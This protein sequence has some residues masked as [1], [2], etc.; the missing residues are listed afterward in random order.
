MMV[1]RTGRSAAGSFW[2]APLL[3]HHAELD[4]RVNAGWPSF[5]AALDAAAK[6]FTE[7]TYANANH[8]F[9]ND[10][11]PHYDKESAELAWQRTVE[12]FNHVLL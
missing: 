2:A 7:Y 12:F 8:G 3:I 4:K 6:E 1:T 5:R 9:H 10:T 11:T